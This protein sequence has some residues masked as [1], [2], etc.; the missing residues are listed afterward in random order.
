MT[1]EEEMCCKCPANC[2]HEAVI[3]LRLPVNW[4][5]SPHPVLLRLNIDAVGCVC[6]CFS[7]FPLHPSPWQRRTN[8]SPPCLSSFHHT[9]PAGG[10]ISRPCSHGGAGRTDRLLRWD[11]LS[12][13]HTVPMR[14]A[15]SV[16]CV[17]FSLKYLLEVI[18]WKLNEA[19]FSHQLRKAQIKCLQP[20]VGRRPEREEGNLLYGQRPLLCPWGMTTPHPKRPNSR[21]TDYNNYLLIRRFRYLYLQSIDDIYD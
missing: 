9:H 14:S 12:E 19:T 7:R 18:L 6:V 13:V 4:N 16:Y 11:G 1:S 10:F 5:V 17:I 2:R 20:A 15:A 3:W 8:Q 21:N